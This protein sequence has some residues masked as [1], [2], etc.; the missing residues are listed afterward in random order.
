MAQGTGTP[1]VTANV[2]NGNLQRQ[3][4][5]TDGVAGIV[6]TAKVA[7]NIGKVVTVYSLTDA[8]TKGY[9]EVAEP[10]LHRHIL[11][12]YNE[13]G[14]SMELWILGVE[15]TMTMESA[16]TSTNVN[17]VKKLLT[18]S[19]GR[20]NLVGVSRNPAVAYNAGAGFLDQDVAKALITSK[21]AAEYQQ[22]INRPL[23]FII[24][25]RVNDED[26]TP[27]F[28]PVTA[29]NTF[30]GVALGGTLNDGS[31]S[32]GIALGRA[33]KYPAH[34][35]IGDGLNGVLSVTSAFIGS[36]QVDEFDPVELNNFT[37]AGYIH[38]HI[39]EGVSG[40]YF[41][42][43]KMAGNDDFN[44]LVRGRLIDKAQRIATSTSTPFLESSV[45]ITKEGNINDADA[46]YLETTIK[47]QLLSLMA[48][49]ISDADVII[50]ID[51]D[52]INTSTLEMQVKIQ[53]LGYLTWIIVNLGLSKTI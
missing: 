35:K 38:Y 11:E 2:T 43:D 12:F 30:S 44:I 8:K 33:V 37:N 40:Y 14:G 49:Q 22:S 7:E 4:Q 32:I 13:V 28:Q 15:D 36:K 47:S 53:P 1:S 18:V 10:H 34:V 39:R 23:R 25:G 24:E 20:V 42:V 6:G 51:Q 45:R 46:V 48:G 27:I 29:E 52:L 3:V 26:V 9:T 16:C 41:S 21:I 5:I 19:K 31:A 17:G 50:P